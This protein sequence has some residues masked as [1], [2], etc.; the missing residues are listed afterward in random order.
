MSDSP[1]FIVNEVATVA[2]ISTAHMKQKD[3]ELLEAGIE[4]MGLSM[5]G[6]YGYMFWSADE[7]FWLDWNSMGFS[8]EFFDNLKAIFS[9][10]YAYIIVDRD[11]PPADNLPTFDW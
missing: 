9:L 8:R 10:G 2:V 5:T 4:P 11:A 3:S 1:A 7:D 6:G